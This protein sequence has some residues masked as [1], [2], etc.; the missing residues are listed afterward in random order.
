MQEAWIRAPYQKW[1]KKMPGAPGTLML[2][3]TQP[4]GED[5]QEGGWFKLLNLYGGWLVIF[6]HEEPHPLCP[7]RE[8]LLQGCYSAQVLFFVEARVVAGD[9]G[10]KPMYLRFVGY[11]TTLQDE[12]QQNITHN[13]MKPSLTRHNKRQGNTVN[14]AQYN[15]Y[16]G[17]RLTYQGPSRSAFGSFAIHVPQPGN[18]LSLHHL[19]SICWRWV[20][21]EQSVA[22]RTAAL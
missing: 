11:H 1:P 16:G 12:A 4:V 6:P 19:Q 22:Q 15:T 2:P 13:T 8:G 21:R 10:L 3:L 7:D 5:E 9:N 18:V 17:M 14:T 20:P